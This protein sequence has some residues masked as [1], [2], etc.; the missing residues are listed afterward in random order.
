MNAATETRRIDAIVIGGSAGALDVLEAVLP[1]L[2]AEFPLPIAVVIHVP[3]DKPSYLIDVLRRRCALAVKEPEDKQP[4]AP[5]TVYIA[6]PN[7]HLLIEKRRCFSLSMDEPV[8]FSRPAIDV[9]FESAADAYGANLA[10]LLLTGANDDGARG[11]VR[12]HGA[13]GLTLVQSPATARVAAMPIAAL[14]LVRPDHVLP[15]QA[16]GPFLAGLAPARPTSPKPAAEG[17]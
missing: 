8:R 3:A 7:Y 2:P 1:D 15:V 9:L 12:I 16:I 10:G 14:A 17:A 5:A 13:G 11:L 6:P 4:L